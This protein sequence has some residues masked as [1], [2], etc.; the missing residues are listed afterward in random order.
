MAD[1]WFDFGG[2]FNPGVLDT[3]GSSYDFLS[4]LPSMGVDDAGVSDFFNVTD[5]V[6]SNMLGDTVGTA[7]TLLG[8]AKKALGTGADI[9]GGGGGEGSQGFVPAR[10][11]A[12]ETA[13]GTQ[14]RAISQATER[15][16]RSSRGE[17]WR[18]GASRSNELIF[19]GFKRATL[20]KVHSRIIASAI[21]GTKGTRV[22]AKSRL[23]S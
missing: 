19:G 20:D 11:T 12:L 18:R 1:D 2:D 23:A 8:F 3:A 4:D 13:I 16:E 5:I 14:T 7:S 17:S 21:A 10:N 22:Q 15:Q 9:L 6:G